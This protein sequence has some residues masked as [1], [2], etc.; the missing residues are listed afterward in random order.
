MLHVLLSCFIFYMKKTGNWCFSLCFTLF[1][2]GLF[3]ISNLNGEL[4]PLHAFTLPS[5]RRWHKPR[6]QL[7]TSNLLKV[8]ETGAGLLI[9]FKYSV[10]H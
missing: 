10:T 2:S 9:F 6:A 7:Q 1:Y 3:L 5:C 4:G 8:T